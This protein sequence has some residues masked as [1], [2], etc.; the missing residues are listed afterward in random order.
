MAGGQINFKVGYTV[1][2]AGLQAIKSSL[3]EIM[4]MKPTNITEFDNNLAKAQNDAR[5]LSD[6]LTKSF[7]KDLGTVNIQKFNAALKASNLDLNR[8]YANMSAIGGQ[9]VASFRNMTTQI[10]TSNLQLKKTHNLLNSMASTL[11]NTIKWGI[12]SSVMNGF[13][14]KTREA[15]SYVKKLDGSLNDIRIVTGKSA[16]EMERFAEKANT[17]AKKLG[18]ATKAYSDASL[19]YYQQG[20]SDNETAARAEVTSKVSNVT[21]QSTEEVS[22]QL[23]AVWNGY[24]VSAEETEMYI[25]KLSAVAATTA[26]NLAEL[27]TGMSK[28]A[29]AAN[30]MGVDID[31]LNAQIST[32]ISVTRQAPESVGTALKTIYARMGDLAIEGEDEFGVSLGEVSGKMEQMGIQV[33]DQQGNLRDMGVIIEET[34]KKWETWT[35]AQ[36]QAAAVAMAGKRQYNNLIALF[37][38]WDK[39]ESALYTSQNSL[40]KLQEQQDI[41]MESS[42]AHLQKMKTAWEDV[43]DSMLDEG[44]INSFAD[45]WGG[46]GNTLATIID[47][48][49]GG[50]EALLMLS[51]ILMQ[52]FSKQIASSIQTFSTNMNNAKYNAQQ[53][54]EKLKL[55]NQV[56]SIDNLDNSILSLAHME[57]A[58]LRLKG[59]MSEEQFNQGQAFIN[60]RKE[61]YNEID[62]LNKAEQEAKE[63]Y[64]QLTG[65]SLEI[66]KSNG[67]ST[68]VDKYSGK[69]QTDVNSQIDM[70]MTEET[71]KGGRLDVASAEQALNKYMQTTRHAKV[72]EEELSG[73]RAKATSALKDL[74][75]GTESL[76]SENQLSL[77]L[78]E[79]LVAA[80][81]KLRESLKG[82]GIERA[83]KESKGARRTAIQAYIR[84]IESIRQEAEKGAKAAK[85]AFDR[86]TTDKPVQ[87]VQELENNVKDFDAYLRDFRA[88]INIQGIVQAFS[89][90]GQ[91]ASSLTTLSNL[92]EI[93]KNEDISTGE[94]FLQILTNIG[95]AVPMLISSLGQL[96]GV[97]SGAVTMQ[98]TLN[99]ATALGITNTEGLTAAEIKELAIK[100]LVKLGMTEEAAAQ[101]VNNS[102]KK[103]STWLTL[104]EIITDKA[105]AIGK[106]LLALANKKVT[107]SL[108][109][110][111]VAMWQIVAVAAIVAAIIYKVVE[112]TNAEAE[113]A[114]EA[115]E[116]AKAQ[117][118]QY[119]ELKN[120]YDEA[121]K[122][123]SDYKAARDGLAQLDNKTVEWTE[124]VK[125]LNEQVIDLI[126]KYPELSKE[127]KNVN[128]QLI[129]T[130]EAL[131]KIQEQQAEDI[132]LQYGVT[133]AL[134][135]NADEKQLA[136]D[137]KK[138][139]KELNSA[140]T[141][142]AKENK[143]THK[144]LN[145]SL[146]ELQQMGER[147]GEIGEGVFDNSELSLIFGNLSDEQLERIREL[148]DSFLPF[149]E[150]ISY[151]TAKTDVSKTDYVKQ[152][153]NIADSPT[154]QDNPWIQTAVAKEY[155]ERLEADTADIY[156][157]FSKANQDIYASELKEHIGKDSAGDVAEWIIEGAFSSVGLMKNEPDVFIDPE[158]GQVGMA[159]FDTSIDL[160]TIVNKYKELYGE[161][162]YKYDWWA[163]QL[164][165]GSKGHIFYDPETKKEIEDVDKVYELIR[166]GM[167][168]QY[169]KDNADKIE[170][171]SQIYLEIFNRLE[172]FQSGLGTSVFSSDKNNI[173]FS[174]LYRQD[175]EKIGFQDASGNV[176]LTSE[177]F[178]FIEQH[179]T[180]MGY[181]SADEM[182]DAY[183][184]GLD[185]YFKNYDGT[186]LIKASLGKIETLTSAL[187]T[188]AE[189]KE[190]DTETITELEN[191][192]SE[193]SKIRDKGSQ[194]YIDALETIR[195]NEEALL[196]L[197]QAFAA[198]DSWK[199]V[200]KT[201]EEYKELSEE[202]EE[203]Q[204]KWVTESGR[205][206]EEVTDSIIKT[207]D[208]LTPLLDDF[209]DKKYEL[210]MSVTDE[211][212]TDVDN[213]VTKAQNAQ[214]AISAIGDG[215]QVAAEDSEKL[216]KIFPELAENAQILADGTIQLDDSVT[217]QILKN[218]GIQ[219]DADKNKT[220]QNIRNRIEE[221]KVKKT[222]AEESLKLLEDSAG[223]ELDLDEILGESK[224]DFYS[225]Q[226]QLSGAATKDEVSNNAQSTEAI[227]N[228]WAAAEEA[229][230]AYGATAAEAAAGK[231]S[232]SAP[233]VHSAKSYGITYTVDTKDTTGE[234]TKTDYEKRQEELRQQLITYRK[235]EIDSYERQIADLTSSW[236]TM[237]DESGKKIEEAAEKDK[238]EIELLEDEKD[239]YHDI[240]IE[241]Q[242]LENSMSK[243][244]DAQEKLYG[245]DL[246]NNLQQQLD[247]LEKQEDAQRRKLAIA[248]QERDDLQD[249]LKAQG[250]TF[251][252]DGTVANYQALYNQKLAETNAKKLAGDENAEDDFNKWLENIERYD[253]LL[254]SEIPDIEQTLRDIA[255]KEIEKQIEAF[256]YEITLKLD[257][258][259]AQ[260]D[261]NE[262]KKNMTVDED[263]ILGS[264][265]FAFDNFKT[266]MGDNGTIATLTNKSNTLLD[267]LKQINETGTSSIYGDN[268]AKLMEDLQ[269]VQEQLMEEMQN[270]KDILDEIEEAYVNMLDAAQEAFDEQIAQYEAINEVY[271][272]GLNVINLMYGEDAY[273]E[274]ED[275]YKKQMDNNNKMIDMQRDTVN[276]Y[277][278][279]LENASLTDEQ[280]EEVQRKLQEA[281]AALHASVES[282]VELIITKY[283]NAINKIFKELEDKM[284]GGMG[285]SHI[286]EE[287]D[288]INQNA[289][290]YLDQINSAY[291]IEKLTRE[292]NKAIDAT[293]SL[294]AQRKLNE[295][296]EQQLKGLREKDKLTQYEVDRANALLDIELKKIALEEA[297]QNKSKMR[298]R[299]DAS[300]NYSYQFVSD[301]DATAQAQQELADAQNSLYNLDKDALQENQEAAL[302]MW[303]EFKDKYIEILSDV[304]L[305]DEEREARLQLIREQYGEMY[306][307]LL[308]QNADI[309]KNLEETAL[310]EMSQM[311]LDYMMNDIVPTW[312]TGVQQ[313]MDAFTGEGGLLPACSTAFNDLKT[314]VG[315]YDADLALLEQNAG[316]SL[317]QIATYTQTVAEQMT[318]V[319]KDNDELISKYA[320]Q[321]EQLGYITDAV[322]GLKGEYNLLT[323]AA[324]AAAKAIL[325]ARY[326]EA[327]LDEEGNPLP[328]LNKGDEDKGKGD[329]GNKIVSDDGK[330]ND[331]D[332]GKEVT[333]NSSKA[334]GVAATIWLDGSSNSGWGTG[335]TRASRLSAK[336]VAA[337]QSIINSQGPSG[338]L[339]KKWWKKDRSAYKY[340]AFET[341]GYTGDWGGDDGRLAILHQKELVLNADDTKNILQAVDIVRHIDGI[342]ES[343]MGNAFSRINNQI[344]GLNAMNIPIGGPT[345]S[346]AA[347]AQH[348]EIN[349]DF[350][351]VEKASEIISAFENL[352]NM[353]TQYAFRS[354]R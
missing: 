96:K 287:W 82:V 11:G 249:S 216:F 69:Q 242:Q 32:I 298:L 331:G 97:I 101:Q 246:I 67:K 205:T 310:T 175:I 202:L 297:Q 183:K 247:L 275:Y 219:I 303:T 214:S 163:E 338:A 14:T 121:L 344:N 248:K 31:Q 256:E 81:D 270:Q 330:K 80:N 336:G 230:M 73:A 269:A 118:E 232:K 253:E 304:T 313:M 251:N 19:I 3:Q 76:A 134:E 218:Y 318:P 286:Q 174:N 283:T 195:E 91:L 349:A 274:M 317:G 198:E 236:A 74:Q 169:I 154:Y 188:V 227:I 178:D 64:Q 44:T 324:D 220:I 94:K 20:L 102:L 284:T 208:T 6:I 68:L 42:A 18:V 2:P 90:V 222:E 312:D 99:I 108:I 87:E 348:I 146:Q 113:A 289:E 43:Y 181:D 190:L 153:L 226:S 235:N 182:I 143:D 210:E 308:L 84:E 152:L 49:G 259:E 135:E 252:A 260:R 271:S 189:G 340:G 130:D 34:A 351:G 10:M 201:L 115:A 58:L 337:A 88:T 141:K 207:I 212:L 168:K 12:A 237:V 314:L 71:G 22:E 185:N 211:L 150:D 290:M 149:L 254:T 311:N 339:Y 282:Q 302:N 173:N 233:R 184:K 13:I 316:Y 157:T 117:R 53:F 346:E 89:A 30:S 215:F 239:L 350:P 104:K 166:K 167:E 293:S 147:F 277:K 28:V 295:L 240:N 296:M 264:T 1:D 5:I 238:K 123:I 329:D 124:N 327:G 333:D 133:L 110:M 109:G 142:S 307:N 300:G 196:L 234:I 46:V 128:G 231:V 342:M 172:D 159:T 291:E 186:A 266:Y 263:D 268:K 93:L 243:L 120:T 223:K 217:K 4:N 25:D 148:K 213:I 57:S 179:A 127:V 100:K 160:D 24:K 83:L 326:A 77:P 65:I 258:R 60:Q 250:T 278:Q 151:N 276:F 155:K 161:D 224:D 95:F 106:G 191:K 341:G 164:P 279:Q 85:D 177:M 272:H 56:A 47:G 145:L 354:D 21:G 111:Q 70:F 72:S 105:S 162:S 165:G 114:K 55:V 170:S 136:L 288:L 9:G 229:A 17:A 200:N 41:Y 335:N 119:V 321:I 38:N 45:L 50:G 92:P 116:A 37:E 35:E 280:R 7:N 265:R 129:L 255:N 281:Q 241:I 323:T 325:K 29:S 292:Y 267:Q 228:N 194:E 204:N 262:F 54:A 36:K 294:S 122:T 199:E 86:I 319:L 103:Q 40:G 8:V 63:F 33:L 48:L 158:T 180:N 27:S 79:R 306:N 138:G 301:E 75:M 156:G 107:I 131:Q 78:Q 206:E 257:M 23:T 221:L 52:V 345:S 51:S 334:E 193:L 176:E 244:Q 139:I 126:K 320:T 66:Q 197:E 144:T 315:E 137:I 59:V 285:L 125:K 98:K 309:R 209:F 299:R 203:S 332:K 61:I 26:S 187:D 132:L 273:A 16:D 322:T 62:A 347:V 140:Y 15:Y 112:A 261:W 192:Y 225:Y 353:A 343:V 39:Y 328:E 245:K 305:T 352:T 171:E